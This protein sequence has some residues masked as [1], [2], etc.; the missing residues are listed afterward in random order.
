MKSWMRLW[1][2]HRVSRRYGLRE[3][4]NGR[5]ARDPRPRGLRLRLA[6]EELGPVFIK[7][8]QALS[9]R[10]DLIPPDIAE[11][12]VKLQDQVGPF[13]GAVA[14]G[15]VERALGK[16]VTELFAEFDETP[17]ATASVAQGITGFF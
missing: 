7:L 2:I 16:P 8:G 9:T 11:E 14:R 5:P 15:I 1:Q 10:P 6:L 17:L 12:L 13:P 3:F 4:L